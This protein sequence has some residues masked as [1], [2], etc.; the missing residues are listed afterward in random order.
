[1]NVLKSSNEQQYLQGLEFN[2][3]SLNNINNLWLFVLAPLCLASLS[4]LSLISLK[5]LALTYFRVAVQSLGF[6]FQHCHP[7]FWAHHNLIPMIMER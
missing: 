3:L 1:M 5:I 7:P 6:L 4:V 2:A